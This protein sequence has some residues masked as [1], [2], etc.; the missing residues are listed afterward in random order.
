MNELTTISETRPGVGYSVAEEVNQI[1][2]EHVRERAEQL[3]PKVERA[4]WEVACLIDRVNQERLFMPD[5]PSFG[6]WGRKRL[7]KRPSE[8][9]KLLQAGRFV[10]E[11]PDEETRERVMRTPPVTLYEAGIPKLAKSD[12]AEAVRLAGEGMTQ[13]ELK[14]AVAVRLPSD[15]HVDPDRLR[16]F[17][18]RCR[19]SDHF[20]LRIIFNGLKLQMQAAHP[21]EPEVVEMLFADVLDYDGLKAQLA[22][23]SERFPLRDIAEGKCCC[24]ECG[25]TNGNGLERHHAVPRSVKGQDEHGRYDGTDGPQVWLCREHHQVVTE[26]IDG[27]WREWVQRWLDRRDMQWFRDEMAAWL[28]PRTLEDVGR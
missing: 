28:G 24:I 5:F 14:Q 2:A 27:T 9:T 11:L 7:H 4:A 3:I 6:E 26:S 10:R 22:P 16:T 25:A 23:L 12:K 18:F 8:L 19:E 1:P 21:T 13:R 20:K 15:H 17:T